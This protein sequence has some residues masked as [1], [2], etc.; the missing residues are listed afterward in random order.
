M[1]VNDIGDGLPMSS[2]PWG[3]TGTPMSSV[4][5]PR[6]SV[7]QKITSLLGGGGSNSNPYGG[8]SGFS[9]GLSHAGDLQGIF[10]GVGTGPGGVGAQSLSG[11]ERIGAGVGTA[12]VVAGGVLGAIKG[13][14]QGGV[15]GDLQGV[16]SILGTAAVPDPEPISKAVLGIGA[17]VTGVISALLPDPRAQREKQI[18][19]TLATDAFLQ[20]ESLAITQST[21]GNYVDQNQFGI[22]RESPFRA[23]SQVQEPY[24]YFHGNTY[25][26]PVPGNVTAPFLTLG[27]TQSPPAVP[28][29]VPTVP[30]GP[31]VANHYYGPVIQ[32]GLHAIDTQSGADFLM[33]QKDTI[34]AAT[35]SHLKQGD[36]ALAQQ[37]RY[38]TSS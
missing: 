33:S 2:G 16:G 22:Q 32:G 6:S 11:A 25:V 19:H 14:S 12:G 23:A 26:A 9:A 35:A 1:P 27:A 29:P 28:A 7:L 21:R 18:T 13:F 34:G 37:V 15:R 20:P 5:A 8:L 3:E 38:L 10:T 4:N 36:T 30:A 24:L 31:G 17:A